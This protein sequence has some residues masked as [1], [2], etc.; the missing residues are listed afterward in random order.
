VKLSLKY[1]NSEYEEFVDSG[2]ATFQDIFVKLYF[3]SAAQTVIPMVSAD[4]DLALF[5]DTVTFS[6]WD[7]YVENVEEGEEQTGLEFSWVCPPVMQ[8]ICDGFVGE[9]ELV[10]NYN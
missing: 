3:A 8:S 6:A 1:T 9:K 10:I 4:T 2:D 5:G 7:T